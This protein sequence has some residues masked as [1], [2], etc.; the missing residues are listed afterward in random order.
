MDSTNS[1]APMP[2]GVGVGV[3][4][5]SGQNNPATV[6]TDAGILGTVE[7]AVDTGVKAIQNGVSVAAEVAAITSAALSVNSKP[8]P[9]DPVQ[10]QISALHDRVSAVESVLNPVV[11]VGAEAAGAPGV[12][13]RVAALESTLESVMAFFK[14]TGPTF[15]TMFADLGIKL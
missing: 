8:A 4:T 5:G 15:T 10:A 6:Q 11:A 7:T 12:V 13:D 9:S 3:P 1:A 14:A 2:V